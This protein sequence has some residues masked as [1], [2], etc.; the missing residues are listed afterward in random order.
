MHSQIGHL[1]LK[2]VAE[3]C[4]LGRRLFLRKDHVPQRGAA[5]VRV[6]LHALRVK[7]LRHKLLR[8]EGQ[9]VR[10]PVHLAELA[11][12]RMD[13]RIVCDENIHLARNVDSLRRQH[14]VHRP[15]QRVPHEKPALAGLAPNQD[16]VFRHLLTASFLPVSARPARFS[17][18]HRT[19]TPQ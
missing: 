4:R 8:R 18:S 19:H 5:A 12:Q 15:A 13:V 10:R 17:Y 3:F 11:V 1:V 16:S 9:N 2:R 6:H 14:G 7:L